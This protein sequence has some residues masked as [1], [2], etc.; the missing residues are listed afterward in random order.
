ME[1]EGVMEVRQDESVTEPADDYIYI[2]Y[3]INK[4]I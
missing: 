4:L 1:T 3:N 2:I